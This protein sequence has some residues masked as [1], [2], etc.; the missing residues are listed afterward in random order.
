MPQIIR[1]TTDS[2]QAVWDASFKEDILIPED[3]QIACY[4]VTT[5]INPTELVIDYQNNQIN[6]SV[7]G[8]DEVVGIFLT[9]GS[10]RS[11]N[12]IDLMND[13]K[14]QLNRTMSYND[15]QIGKQWN[16]YTVGS[17]FTVEC[18]RGAISDMTLNGTLTGSINV[19]TQD[20]GGL[21][22]EIMYSTQDFPGSNS[23]FFYVK[24][25]VCKGAASVRAQ[26]YKKGENMATEKFIM[27]VSKNCPDQT[28]DNI[29]INS[30]VFGLIYNNVE[31]TYSLV[32]GGKIITTDVPVIYFGENNEGNDLV[33]LD[34]EGESI[35]ARVYRG[36]NT[37]VTIGEFSQEYDH[38]QDLFPVYVF[39]GTSI[40]S[41][42][43]T[44][45]D[46]FYNT[47]A[48]NVS[49]RVA[50]R[51]LTILPNLQT[52]QTPSNN[53][54]QFV[55]P[56]IAS[57]F[58]FSSPRLPPGDNQ[59]YL[60]DDIMYQAVS[61]WGLKA[62]SDS[63]IVQLL[64]VN[65]P[66]SYDSDSGQRVNYLDIIPSYSI[67]RERVVYQSSNPIYLDLQNKSVLN[68]RALRARLLLEDG[69]SP[70][71]YGTSQLTL[72]VRRRGEL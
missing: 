67:I 64:N 63:Y 21:T 50:K 1:L 60:R 58:G 51:N 3:S 9:P 17:F 28:T 36:D 6:Y 5:N 48:N 45:T 20:V 47:P 16:V 8:G 70:S 62:Y 41:L 69:S 38:T 31:G 43:Q 57:F 33:T 23:A 42:I 26:L 4:S 39:P 72:L 37:K 11:D 18:L 7:Q 29:N 35:Y 71:T 56:Y 54:L 61:A 2:T 10:F 52:V 30:I 55:D 40:W 44:S 66:Q 15:V 25:P 14:F 53:F 22:G 24:S 13:M 34:F 12:V 49:G 32:E 65:L 59:Y 68:F 19:D 46:P 27:G